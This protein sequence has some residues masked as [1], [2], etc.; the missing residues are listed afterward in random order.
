MIIWRDAR[1]LRPCDRLSS[2]PSVI[3]EHLIIRANKM[4]HSCYYSLLEEVE[5]GGMESG[6]VSKTLR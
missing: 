1:Y 3:L 2:P 4:T 6:K 5:S